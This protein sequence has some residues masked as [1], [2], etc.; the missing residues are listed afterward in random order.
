MSRYID[1]LENASHDQILKVLL[2]SHQVEAIKD[3]VEVFMSRRHRVQHSVLRA[4]LIWSITAVKAFNGPE[5]LPNEAYLRKTLET[6]KKE[7]ITDAAKAL[8]YMQK[9]SEVRKKFVRTPGPKKKNPEWVDEYMEE[10][11]EWG[12]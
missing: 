5:A 10:L 2:P 7:N 11:K 1:M 6:F 3:E 8:N 9:Q 12:K 4:V